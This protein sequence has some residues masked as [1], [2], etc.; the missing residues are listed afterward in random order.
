MAMYYVEPLPNSLEISFTPKENKKEGLSRPSPMSR[1]HIDSFYSDPIDHLICWSLIVPVPAENRNIISIFNQSL[2]FVM[3]ARVGVEG[4]G[5][6]HEDA[7]PVAGSLL[8]VAR[9]WFLDH[10]FLFRQNAIESAQVF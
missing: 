7:F 5:K 4:V 3:D 2:C 10:H 6:K 9:F 8:L 1:P